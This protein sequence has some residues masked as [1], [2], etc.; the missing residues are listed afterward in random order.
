[1]NIYE[2]ENAYLRHIH[3]QLKNELMQAD[4]KTTSKTIRINTEDSSAQ[5]V[6]NKGQLIVGI[7]SVMA[8]LL[9]IA[10]GIFLFR[11]YVAGSPHF[12]PL[13]KVTGIL[14]MVASI[15]FLSHNTKNNQR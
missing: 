10:L 14:T 11:T 12:W 15:A 6:F 4:L 9:F 5:L 2:L 1:M 13:L 3:R 7:K 8:I